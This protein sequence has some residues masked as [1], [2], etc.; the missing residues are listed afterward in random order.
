M[1]VCCECCVLSSRDLC[2]GLMTQPEE[3]LSVIVYPRKL[4]G[5]GPLAAVTP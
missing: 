3:Y 2:D 1:S 4:E 5:L